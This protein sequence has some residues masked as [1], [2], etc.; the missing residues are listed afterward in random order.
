LA[1]VILTVRTKSRQRNLKGALVALLASSLL[2]TTACPVSA[3]CDFVLE[4]FDNLTPPALPPGWV[5]SQGVNLTGAPLWVT[6]NVGSHTWPNAAFSTAPDNI[7]DN[8][9]DTPLISTSPINYGITFQSS[10]NL[11]SGHDGAVLEISSPNINGGAFTDITDPAVNGGFTSGGYN[12]LITSPSS[13][14]AGRMAWS[15]NSGGYV[16]TRALFGN[17]VF[18]DFHSV[19]VRFRLVSDNSGASEGW[20]IDTV[21][22]I[23]NECPSPPPIPAPCP[24]H[25]WTSAASYPLPEISENAMGSNFFFAYSAGGY[26]S[27]AE[28]NAAY[29]YEAASGAWTALAPLPVALGA[30]SRRLFFFSKPGWLLCLWR[31]QPVFRPRHD[32]LL[33][34]V[35]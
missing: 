12:T 19:K 3:G 5:A 13:P 2:V 31:R 26:T 30:R 8:R 11:E 29:S 9:L 7:L 6:S 16:F 4:N 34:R 35:H 27:S 1:L 25:P 20:R 10:Y 33:R 14:I 17:A 24:L 22:Q 28:T 23:H 18:P 21:Y 32:V 15:G